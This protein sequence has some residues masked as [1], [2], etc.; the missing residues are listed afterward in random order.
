MAGIAFDWAAKR[1]V[2]L[3]APQLYS[4]VNLDKLYF[5][6][7]I[8][9]LLYT[10]F[11]NPVYSDYIHTRNWLSFKATQTIGVGPQ[12]EYTCNFNTKGSG[13]KGTTAMPLGGH[14]ELAFGA[15]NSLGLFLGYELS[16]SVRTNAGGNAAEGRLTFVHNF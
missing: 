9:T 10:S 5:E 12:F 6:S 15:G 7:W 1:A 3:N 16:K 14:V 4:V 11:K 8:W 2:A 13:V